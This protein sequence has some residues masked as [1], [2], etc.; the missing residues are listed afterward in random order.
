VYP[1]EVEA[2]IESHPAV[3]EVAAVGVSDALLGE[4]ICACIVPV[5]GA[6]V[7]GQEIMDWCRETLADPKIPDLV[8]FVDELPR[9]DTGQ[10][11]RTDL[12]RQVAEE[13]SV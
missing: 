11:R 8:R 10:V 3:Q 1:R 4:S 9:T 2:R 6:I 7:T 5:E 12:S 13:P